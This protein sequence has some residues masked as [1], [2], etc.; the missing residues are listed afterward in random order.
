[1]TKH[2]IRIFVANL[3][4]KLQKNKRF[5]NKKTSIVESL[6]CLNETKR[7]IHFQGSKTDPDTTPM[8]EKQTQKQLVKEKKTEIQARCNSF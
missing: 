6:K 8:F 5:K 3:L 2:S 4:F 7:L 1:M